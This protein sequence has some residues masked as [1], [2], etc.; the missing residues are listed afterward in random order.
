MGKLKDIF[1]N[2]K[3]L[4]QWVLPLVILVWLFMEITEYGHR[5]L[6]EGFIE[7]FTD[8]VLY[9]IFIGVGIV[10]FVIVYFVKRNERKKVEDGEL[11]NSIQEENSSNGGMTIV[12]IVWIFVMILGYFSNR[13]RKETEKRV[14]D[15][16]EQKKIEQIDLDSQ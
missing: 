1:T 14:E 3:E 4:P 9:Y 6:V 11:D 13:H 16:I 7:D 5:P 2:Q 8:P 12:V 10:F 15:F